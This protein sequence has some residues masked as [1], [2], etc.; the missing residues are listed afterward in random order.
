MLGAKGKLVTFYIN[1]DSKYPGIRVSI[2]PRLRTM[3]SLTRMLEEK[4][5]PIQSGIRSVVS[6]V[7]MQGAALMRVHMFEYLKMKKSQCQ[8][9]RT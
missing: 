7:M 3:E 9:Y 6:E 1:G 2:M 8:H 4:R 5:M